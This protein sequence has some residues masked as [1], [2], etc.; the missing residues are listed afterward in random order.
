MEVI[1]ENNIVM[2]KKLFYE[3]MLRVSKEGYGKFAKKAM[4]VLGALWAVLAAVTLVSGGGWLQTLGYLGILVLIGAWLCILMPRSNARRAYRTLCSKCGEQMERTIRFYAEHMQ[5]HSAET[6]TTIPY[7][8]VVS[9]LFSRHLLVLTCAD[10]RGVMLALDGF[11]V[12]NPSDV[13]Q[14]IKIAKSED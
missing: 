13:Q 10:K 11:S 7:T 4:L 14:L 1:A 2:T 9:V 6:V 12:G 3:G 8:D 5:I